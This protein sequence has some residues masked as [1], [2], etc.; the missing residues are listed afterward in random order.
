[1]Y[2]KKANKNK[3]IKNS[4]EAFDK[5]RHRSIELFSENMEIK[6]AY[7]KISAQKKEIEKQRDKIE[8]N[9]KKLKYTVEKAKRRT[10]D[11]F[12]KHIDLKKAKKQIEIMEDLGIFTPEELGLNL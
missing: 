5:V 1:M 11:L 12:G 6:K 9:N 7:K 3:S 4:K 8:L 2:E 10:I